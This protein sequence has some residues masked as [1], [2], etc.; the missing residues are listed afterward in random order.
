MHIVHCIKAKNIFGVLILSLKYESPVVREGGTDP[1]ASIS[2]YTDN[3]S[4]HCQTVYSIEVQQQL[5]K[6]Q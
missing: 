6:C 3:S 4:K 2:E 1:T 5:I